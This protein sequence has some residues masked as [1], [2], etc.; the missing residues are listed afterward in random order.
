MQRSFLSTSQPRKIHMDDMMEAFLAAEITVVN[1]LVYGSKSMW[2]LFLWLND[3]GNADVELDVGHMLTMN[4]PGIHLARKAQ[5]V[6]IGGFEV[7][8]WPMLSTAQRDVG[9]RYY[10]SVQ[11]QSPDPSHPINGIVAVKVWYTRV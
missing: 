11:L 6:D 4:P 5:G 8:T 10:G 3:V 2:V 9:S 1:V 7:S